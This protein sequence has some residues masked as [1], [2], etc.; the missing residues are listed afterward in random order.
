MIRLTIRMTGASDARSF[1]CWT[2]ASKAISSPR[3]ST[4]PMIWPSAVLPVPYRRSSAASS[5]VGIATIGR[6]SRPVTIRNAPIVYSSVGSAIARASS[7]SSSRTGS[8]RH[9]RRNRCEMRS[10]RIGNSGY[11]ATSTIGR[12]SCAASASAT[13]RC[14]QAPSVTSSAPSFSPE[15]CCRRSARSS[16][17]ASSLPRSI[18]I[19]PRRLRAGAFKG[20][21]G[22]DG[23]LDKMGSIIPYG[24]PGHPLSSR[25]IKWLRTISATNCRISPTRAPN[26][27]RISGTPAPRRRPSPRC[28]R[29][30]A[31]PTRSRPRTRSARGT[32]RRR[33]SRGRTC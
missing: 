18:R 13:S 21:G 3:C 1:S 9:S 19:S 25:Q 20:G 7:C 12:P 28:P 27:G 2:S 16:P 23:A 26:W 31:P 22:A 24:P 32:R 11:V 14:A 4:S 10:S 29:R 5:S 17:A 30:C 8:A 6:I 15:S 33:A